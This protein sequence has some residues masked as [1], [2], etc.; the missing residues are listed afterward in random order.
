ME[1]ERG[2]EGGPPSG[3]SPWQFHFPQYKKKAPCCNKKVEEGGKKR[4]KI[5]EA[6]R[7]RE[8]FSLWH[9]CLSLLSPLLISRQWQMLFFGHTHTHTGAA[10]ATAATEAAAAAAA[11]GCLLLNNS[12]VSH[13]HAD[14]VSQDFLPLLSFLSRN[15]LLPCPTRHQVLFRKAF[16]SGKT[17]QQQQQ[18]NDAL[19]WSKI[20]TWSAF[21]F[22]EACLGAGAL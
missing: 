7:A 8:H 18:Q 17:V 19:K 11:A 13:T 4:R 20:P 15:S 9:Y 5:R 16:W 2:R 14:T 3:N 22:R 1:E 10:A 12:T 21:D 6:P